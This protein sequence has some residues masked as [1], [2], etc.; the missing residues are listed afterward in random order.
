MNQE[1]NNLQCTDNPEITRND[2]PNPD[3]ASYS[4]TEPNQPTSVIAEIIRTEV[5]SGPLPHPTLL[6][7]YNDIIPN[8]AERIM[9]MSE[10]EQDSIISERKG[11]RTDNKDISMAKIN[12][13]KR[14]QTM[15]FILALILFGLATL[16]VMTG[17]E[18]FA[19][20]LFSVGAISLIGLF[21]NSDKDIKKK[22]E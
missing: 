12:L 7:E 5:S 2:Y 3:I 21:V 22:Q 6:R 17:H 18:T 9:Q 20:I 13:I 15:G 16:F 19:Y 14:G 11:V 8:G 1:P 4:S 10:K